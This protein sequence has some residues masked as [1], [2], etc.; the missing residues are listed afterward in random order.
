MIFGTIFI[1]NIPRHTGNK[2]IPDAA[3]E[4]VFHRNTGIEA[5]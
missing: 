3:M 1:G 5:G 2:Q 4:Y